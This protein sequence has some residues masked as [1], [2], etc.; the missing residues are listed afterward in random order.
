M[1]RL[2]TVMLKK[3]VAV[4]MRKVVEKLKDHSHFQNFAEI[5]EVADCFSY[6]DADY[7]DYVDVVG[8]L[9]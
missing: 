6:F 4:W 5:V 3:K 2:E 8:F 7:R 1:S 9:D